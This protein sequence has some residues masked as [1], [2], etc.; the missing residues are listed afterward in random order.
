MLV[1]QY[2]SLTGMIS[3]QDLVS[4]FYRTVSP[5]IYVLELRKEKNVY[6]SKIQITFY[7]EIL[8]VNEYYRER[9]FSVTRKT[10]Y[11]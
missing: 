8:Q 4:M 2:M 5:K 6:Q 9:F 1:M 3:T 10:N 7:I 11:F